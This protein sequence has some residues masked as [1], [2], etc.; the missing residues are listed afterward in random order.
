[1]AD[2][3]ELAQ[4]EADQYPLHLEPVVIAPAVQRA[5][6]VVDQERKAR[7]L[8]LELAVAPDLREMEARLFAPE[9]M[10]LSLPGDDQE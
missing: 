8:C 9:R 3:L 10:G 1:V 7:G 4:S 2:L 5:L 6:E